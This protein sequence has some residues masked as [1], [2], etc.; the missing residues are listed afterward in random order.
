MHTKINEPITVS[1]LFAGDRV[2]PQIF[3]WDGRTYPVSQVNLVYEERNGADRVYHF[4]VSNQ[5]AF[6]KLSFDT[7]SLA[8]RLLDLYVE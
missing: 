2:R 7:R 4:A 5:E 1:A 8:W 6:F 3:K